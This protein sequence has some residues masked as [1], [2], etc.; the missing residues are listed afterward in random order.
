MQSRRFYERNAEAPIQKSVHEF[1][2]SCAE[3]TE[4]YFAVPSQCTS[5]HGH[6]MMVR[7]Y[8]QCLMKIH[9][10]IRRGDKL[11]PLPFSVNRT[12]GYNF[13]SDLKLALPL[14]LFLYNVG[15]YY[16]FLWLSRVLQT[17]D[18]VK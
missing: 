6:I 11:F 13:L 15:K 7:P 5:S 9:Q 8:C 10:C 17:T 3:V 14:L 4:E 2:L 12:Q 16:L 18:S 1:A